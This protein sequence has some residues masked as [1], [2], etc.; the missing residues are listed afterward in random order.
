MRMEGTCDFCGKEGDWDAGLFEKQANVKARPNDWAA[1]FPSNV[2]QLPPGCNFSADSLKHHSVETACA[3]PRC[4]RTPNA[5]FVPRKR[6]SNV[7]NHEAWKQIFIRDQWAYDDLR[8][9]FKHDCYR[10][11]DNDTAQVA[12]I[13]A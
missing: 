12:C 11:E 2:E 4:V 9:E 5:R 1:L 6:N 8:R 10:A 3:C 13:G 7:R